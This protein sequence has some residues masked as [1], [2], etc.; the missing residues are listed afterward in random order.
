MYIDELAVEELGNT[1]Q[2]VKAQKLIRE[3]EQVLKGTFA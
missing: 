1:Q 2:T 3:V